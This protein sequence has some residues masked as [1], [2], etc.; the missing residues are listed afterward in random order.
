MSSTADS[1]A[2]VAAAGGQVLRAA[3]AAMAAVRPASK[4]LHPRGDVIRGTLTRSGATPAT[5]VPWLDEPG[6]D[7]VQARLSRAVGLPRFLPDIHGLALRVPTPTGF[8]D[9]L[10]ASTGTGRATRFVL[11]VAR[12]PGGRPMTTLLPYRAPAG[13]VL[14]GAHE[15]AHGRWELVVAS[16]RGP[17]RSFGVLELPD[18]GE[19]ASVSF[20]PVRNTIPGLEVDDWV[21]RLR[22]PAYRTARRTR[23]DEPP[24]PQVR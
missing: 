20:D 22:E 9:V 21:R 18:E 24:T 16:L 23:A 5:G 15:E 6:R 19:D 10:L 1:R 3:T 12:E 7:S 2:L 17:W 13:A 8:G 14:L 4:P 11:T